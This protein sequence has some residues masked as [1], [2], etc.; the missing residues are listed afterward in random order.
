LFS[1]IRYRKGQKINSFSSNIK[2]QSVL[3]SFNSKPDTTESPE[4]G[5]LIEGLLRPDWS[6]WLFGVA[7]VPTVGS[8]IPW[9]VG[10]GQ[11]KKTRLPKHESVY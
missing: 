6:W 7:M 1:F 9:K 11:Y 2:I 8:T 4:M 10:P 3:V 5:V